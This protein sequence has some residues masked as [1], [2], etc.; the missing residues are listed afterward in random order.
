MEETADR[1]VSERLQMYSQRN[2]VKINLT[3]INKESD[4]DENND[5]APRGSDASK[6]LH[7]RGS[8]RS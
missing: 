2:L 1:G 7:R 8:L 6:K 4:C 5:N 3:S